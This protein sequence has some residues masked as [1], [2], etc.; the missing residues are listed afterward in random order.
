MFRENDTNG[1]RNL[2]SLAILIL[3][4]NEE[5]NIAAV[6]ENARQCSDEVVIVDSGSTDRTV[7]LAKA[8]GARVVYRAWDN[9]FAAQRNFALQQTRSDWVL[10]LDADE[11]LTASL[12]VSVKEA[13]A[14]NENKQYSIQRKSSA[15]GKRFNYGVLYPDWVPRLFPRDSVV[16]VGQVH[17][18]PEC[19]LPLQKLSGFMEHYT[20]R[21]WQQWETKMSRYTT[22]W[23]RDAYKRG[24]RTSLAGIFFH[25]IGGFLKMC[26]VKRGILDG[27]MGF[28]LCCLHFFYT[29]LKYLKLYERQE[30]KRK[31]GLT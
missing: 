24:R 20:Y 23:A 8:A 5:A 7:E 2:N 22:I 15:F 31:S 16:W 14:K 1:G 11:R 13:V 4:K 26:F 25:G 29:T 21:S 28:Y 6:I 30:Q 9:D 12:Q 10:Y 19:E 18:H 3:T 17:E 27:W